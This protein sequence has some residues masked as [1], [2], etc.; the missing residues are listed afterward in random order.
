M[1]NNRVI[2]L[3]AEDPPDAFPPIDAALLEPDGLVA[4]GGDLSSARLLCAY[5]RG[6][7]PWYDDGQPLLWWSP[8]PRCVFKPGNFHVSRR[9]RRSMRRSTSK[10]RFNTDFGAVIRACAAPR[11]AEHGTWITADMIAAYERLHREGWAH[12]V[13]VWEDDSLVGGVYGLAIGRVFFGESMFSRAE[14]ASKIALLAIS[15]TMDANKL[16]LLDCQ[17]VSSHL[18]SLGASIIPR[19]EFVAMLDSLCSPAVQFENWPDTPISR[20]R[21]GAVTEAIALQ[22]P[23]RF[24][25]IRQPFSSREKR[26]PWQKKKP[27]RWKASLPRRCPTPLSG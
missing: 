12:S 2:W 21:T 18:L 27:F 10:V 9:M 22:Y 15:R 8:D 26:D 20:C 6:I 23:G 25:T 13:E 19:S 24:C 3:S 16:G 14:D 5:Q 17:I 11:G 7:F 4:A 1:S